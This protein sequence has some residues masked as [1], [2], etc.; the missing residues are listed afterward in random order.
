MA[1]PRGAL[2]AALSGADLVEAA[3]RAAILAKGARRTVA[4]VARATAAAVLSARAAPSPPPAGSG[5]AEGACAE[6]QVRDDS[7][8]KGKDKYMGKVLRRRR[9]RQRLAE[10]KRTAAAAADAMDEDVINDEWADDLRCDAA[11]RDVPL[12][13]EPRAAAV[14]AAPLALAAPVEAVAAPVGLALTEMSEDVAAACVRAVAGRL[15]A[16]PATIVEALEAEFRASG[17]DIGALAAGC[18][19]R[20]PR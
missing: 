13:G 7:E 14:A 17:I 19:G 20:P 1:K 6:V 18:G 8:D 15:D 5:R 11:G 10:A 9:R 3:V 4:A 16:E 12:A 2:P